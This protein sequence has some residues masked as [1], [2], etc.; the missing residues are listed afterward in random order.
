M[1]ENKKGE[2]YTVKFICNNCGA[3][4]KREF[5]FGHA[6][7]YSELLFQSGITHTEDAYTY[8]DNYVTCSNCGSKNISKKHQ[9]RS[10][11]ENH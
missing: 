7:Q 8:K 6:V 11:N 10:L 2:K 1:T 4:F 9:R 5:S 3:D